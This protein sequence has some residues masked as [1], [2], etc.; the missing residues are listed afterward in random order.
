MHSSYSCFTCSKRVD[1]IASQLIFPSSWASNAIDSVPSLFIINV[2]VGYRCMYYCVIE[3]TLLLL[4]LLVYLWSFCVCYCYCYC[5][6]SLISGLV[7]IAALHLPH[8]C[9]PGDHGRARVVARLLFQ[10]D[11]GSIRYMYVYMY[12]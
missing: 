6:V 8:Q 12:M 4:Y 3:Y 9:I 5:T 11:R 2:Q 10:M 7:C 1:N